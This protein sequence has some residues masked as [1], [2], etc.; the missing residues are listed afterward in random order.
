MSDG[1]PFL[2]G[3]V[4]KSIVQRLF[5]YRETL[6]KRMIIFFFGGHEAMVLMKY[7]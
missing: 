7:C 5:V 6:Y 4:L 1:I 2:D 3:I